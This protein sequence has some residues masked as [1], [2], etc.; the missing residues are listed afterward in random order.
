MQKLT[1]R[2]EK[3]LPGHPITVDLRGKL[4]KEKDRFFAIEVPN[5]SSKG[6]DGREVQI[7]DFRGKVVLFYV[8]A[9]Y[10]EYSRRENVKL[11]ELFR[12][13]R[14]ENFEIVDYS[15]DDNEAAWRQAVA[16][17]SLPW[18]HH[19]ISPDGWN[20]PPV[21]ELGVRSIPFTYLLDARG[22]LRSKCLYSTDLEEDV[23]SLVAAWR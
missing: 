9:S 5:F 1:G 13:K 18:T 8:W 16:E 20:C 19:L 11:A 23:D 6:L 3:E 7:T 17:D 14:H 22:I 21:S 4:N 2:L 10:C 15:I 12:S